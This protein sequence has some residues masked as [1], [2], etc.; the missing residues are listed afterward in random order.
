MFE[1]IRINYSSE[2][3]KRVLK[4][5]TENPT[6]NSD[7]EIT[8]KREHIHNGNRLKIGL[9]PKNSIIL[10]EVFLEA[11]YSYEEAES[12]MVNGFQSWS[13]SKEYN[14]KERQKG[15]RTYLRPLYKKWRLENFGDHYL[16]SYPKRKG[17]FHGFTYGY[18]RQKNGIFFVGSLSEKEGFSLLWFNTHQKHIR[19]EKDVK[20]LSLTEEYPLYDV[21]T[22][23]DEENNAFDRYTEL[24]GLSDW[25]NKG[26][27]GWTS[28]YYHYHNISESIIQKNLEHFTEHNIPLDIFQIDDG[29]QTA[30]G[31]WLDVDSQKFPSGMRY[32]SDSIHQKSYKAGIWLAPFVC[33][34]DSTLMKKHPEWILKDINGKP[35]P[36]GYNPNNWSGNF[37]ILDFY[38]HHVQRYLKEVFSTVFNEWNFDMVKLDF[39]YA[40]SFFPRNG[41]PRAKVLSD[42]LLFIREVCGDN[43]I[44]GCGVPLGCGFG[45]F[46]FCRI[47]SD[48]APYWEDSRLS[49]L[50]YKER[51]SVINSLRST[52]AR[53][54][55]NFR[56]FINDPDVFILR[57]IN[58][59]MD[60]FQR[61]TLFIL[62][63]AF[64]GLVFTSDDISEY[65]VDQMKMY[66]KHFPHL[67]KKVRI[68][69]YQNKYIESEMKAAGNIYRI[70]C[71]LSGYSK[72]IALP[73]GTFS[74]YRGEMYEGPDTLIL[75]SFQTRCFLVHKN[76]HDKD[77]EI[78]SLLI[79]T[80]HI[81]PGN[82]FSTFEVDANEARITLH[83]QADGTGEVYI[84]LPD[85]YKRFTINGSNCYP[86][87]HQKFNCIHIKQDKLPRSK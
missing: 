54:Q 77:I 62:N 65:S 66:K 46:D 30:V 9:K 17:V 80:G 10:K 51:V 20:D 75:E 35:F 29:Y 14:L 18:V 3:K 49:F 48:V 67:A 85:N 72:K 38:N 34:E 71:N 86:V 81:F 70:F 57:S 79:S 1:H 74:D 41:K 39:L 78:P 26:W 37:Y 15:L 55:L 68:I 60:F 42:A 40:V 45:L 84:R 25:E 73:E 16:A 22:I 87:H 64:G 32:I 27:T 11:S 76:T 63:C 7:L 24:M 33:E 43:L 21:V 61:E 13:E 53:A 19:I 31:D 44:L 36:I 12:I 23:E 83:P 6:E 28:W 59:S 5:S 47:G 58:Q 56:T 4:C 50:K 2:G 8:S 69:T 82:E 52:I